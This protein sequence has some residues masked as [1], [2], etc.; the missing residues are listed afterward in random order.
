[1]KSELPYFVYILTNKTNKVLY[2]GRTPDLPERVDEHRKH[3]YPNAF[4]VRYQVYK[5]VYYEECDD[6][7]HAAHRE[8]QLKAGSRQQ[9]LD[10]IN[11]LNPERAD[12]LDRWDGK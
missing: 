8:H 11:K 3:M 1:M 2:V 10:L 9:K 7:A 12:L 5:L 4:T 6:L